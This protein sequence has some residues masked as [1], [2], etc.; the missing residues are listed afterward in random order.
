M[1]GIKS[2]LEKTSSL[3]LLREKVAALP[4][5]NLMESLQAQGVNLLQRTYLRNFLNKLD[6]VPSIL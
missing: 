1:E 6:L 5:M 2:I 4:F 3:D